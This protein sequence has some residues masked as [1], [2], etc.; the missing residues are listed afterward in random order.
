MDHARRLQ[1][2]EF[3]AQLQVA[4]D[5]LA[6]QLRS[7]LVLVDQ[8]AK[9]ITL[10]SR[11]PLFC[12]E[13]K[14]CARCQVQFIAQPDRVGDSQLIHCPNGRYVLVME[15][16]IRTENGPLYLLA[17]RTEER[18][19]TKRYAALLQAIYTLPFDLPL[20]VRRGATSVR[21]EGAPGGSLTPQE[22]RVLAYVAA[23]LT[24]KDIANEL[25]IS[26]STVK[27]H[28]RS[29]LKKLSLS[30]RTEASVYALRNGISLENANV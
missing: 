10:P 26:Q 13:Q 24:N 3:F 9:E 11:L 21:G 22:N 8:D 4:Q 17:G 18:A 30:N 25:C 16:S 28:V 5:L 6:D 20:P 1:Y 23:G 29:I 7:C 12:N 14:G 27:A 15:T 2:S 19:L